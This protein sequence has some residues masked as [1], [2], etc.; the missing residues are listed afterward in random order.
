MEAIREI[1]TLLYCIKNSSYTEVFGF[2]GRLG[3]S[4]I[5]RYTREFVKSE[6]F[7]GKYELGTLEIFR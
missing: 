2:T 6:H 1:E 3:T 4:H 5:F 7:N